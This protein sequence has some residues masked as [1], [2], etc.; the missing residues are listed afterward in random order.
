MLHLIDSLPMGTAQLVGFVLAMLLTALF[1]VVFAPLSAWWTDALNAIGWNAYL[2]EAITMVAN[3]A[4]EY[5]YQRFVVF[6]KSLDTA[7]IQKK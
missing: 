2:V 6:R 4:A 5:L 1:Y 3:F 7:P